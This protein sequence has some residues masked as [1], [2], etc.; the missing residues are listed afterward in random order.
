MPGMHAVQ[1]AAMPGPGMPAGY[2]AT[3]FMPR[4]GAEGAA[5]AAAAAAAGYPGMQYAP[6]YAVQLPLA[7]HMQQ[8]RT[9][10]K[11]CRASVPVCPNDEDCRTSHACTCRSCH[12]DPMRSLRRR[13]Q[14]HQMAMAHLPGP[15]SPQRG[16]PRG[17]GGPGGRGSR[18]SSSS[19]V[20]RHQRCALR[21]EQSCAALAP[22]SGVAASPH[23]PKCSSGA[24]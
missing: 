19:S 1:F 18:R 22:V 15:P 21:P 14:Q 13:L 3:A 2:Q 10:Q 23:A 17:P 8:V 12:A 4:P 20:G 6:G 11:A 24:R 5:M 7:Q 16:Y 9:L